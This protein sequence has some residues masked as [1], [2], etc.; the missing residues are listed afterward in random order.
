MPVRIEGGPF[1]LA[2]LVELDILEDERSPLLDRL[3]NYSVIHHGSD[4]IV[5]RCRGPT[6][7]DPSARRLTDSYLQPLLIQIEG[8]KD[9]AYF[10]KDCLSLPCRSIARSNSPPAGAHAVSA[11]GAAQTAK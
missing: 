7:L 8:S 3:H 4:N 1:F 9:S 2:L 6:D 11:T 10:G 5:E